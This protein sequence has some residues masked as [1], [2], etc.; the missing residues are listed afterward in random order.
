MGLLAEPECRAA[1]M[2]AAHGIDASSVCRRFDLVA[3]DATDVSRVNRIS[4]DWIECLMA[5]EQ[6][7][8]NYPRPLTLATEHLLLGIVAAENEVS[9]WLAAQGL[10]VEPLQA[11]IHRLNGY[12]PGPLP[13]EPDVADGDRPPDPSAA[14]PLSEPDQRS[15]MR[16]IDAAANRANEGLRVAEDYVRFALDDWHL[17]GQCKAIRH[18]LAAALGTFSNLERTAARDTLG[19]VGTSI[20]LASEQARSDPAAV[21]G[22]NLKR[23]QQSLRSLEEFSKCLPVDV[24][25]TFEQLRYRT[26]TL[27]RAIDTTNDALKRL[28]G[29]TLYVLIDAGPSVEAFARLVDALV[30][31]EVGAIQLREKRLPDRALLDRAR[32]LR[33]HTAGSSTLCIVNDR[34]DVA[35]LCV[36]DGV[37]VGHA[38]LPLDEV[39]RV[40]GVERLVGVSTHSIEQARQAVMDGASYI[41]V[42]PTFASETK[43]FAEFPGPALLA[44]VASEIRLPAFAI[45]GV[46]LE[47]LDAVLQTGIRRVA[48]SSAIAGA[49][50]PAEAA[51]EFI[52][53]LAND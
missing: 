29:T 31:A 2:L 36:A 13:L 37:H 17:T 45:G 23:V 43:Q 33:E 9:Q 1:L 6:R 20:S 35:L 7:L 49:I 30:T 14:A 8:E 53:A 26:Y 40:I 41:G 18:D 50:N 47:N 24:A 21:A 48:V 22:A 38:E 3:S 27:E 11:E 10:R 16:A 42:G 46:S 19:D 12:D 51:A 52:A 44:S 4:T 34:P 15:V 39:R 5:A 25:A 28:E 32:L